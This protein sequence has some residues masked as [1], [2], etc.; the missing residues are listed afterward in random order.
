MISRMNGVVFFGGLAALISGCAFGPIAPELKPGEFLVIVKGSPAPVEV[1]RRFV[2]EQVKIN[3][4][5]G[6]KR[7]VPAIETETAKPLM[8]SFGEQL[9]YRC[10]FAQSSEAGSIFTTFTMAYQEA[11]KTSLVEMK[12]TTSA[13]CQAKTCFGGP[14][15]LW[16]VPCLTL[17]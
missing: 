7:E 17:C 1:I 4:L 3:K 12:F 6:C 10:V 13:G 2:E 15:Q 5:P 16:R 11:I 9:V 8:A 14:L